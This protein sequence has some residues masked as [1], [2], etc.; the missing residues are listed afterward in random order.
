L[1]DEGLEEEIR[2]T[3]LHG[4]AHHLGIDDNRLAE[5]GWD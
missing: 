2:R 4:L 3:V 1:T 5:L